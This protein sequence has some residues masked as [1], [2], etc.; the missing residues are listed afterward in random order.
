MNITNSMPRAL[1]RMLTRLAPAL[2]L[3]LSAPLVSA[4]EL[5]T[6]GSFETGTPAPSAT[7]GQ[8]SVA[9]GN[10]ANLPGW[11]ASAGMGWYFKASAWGMT[12]PDGACLFNLYGTTGADTHCNYTPQHN[13]ARRT[14]TLY[15][16]HVHPPIHSVVY[17]VCLVC[18]VHLTGRN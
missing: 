11:T 2:A 16:Y 9:A 3:G 18:L 6:N 17:L 8:V 14:G 5:I 15:P 13:P 12:T 1:R 10:T 4:A 7:S